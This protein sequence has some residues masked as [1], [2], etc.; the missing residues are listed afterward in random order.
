MGE[1]NNTLD[2][3]YWDCPGPVREVLSWPYEKTSEALR[4]I[5]GD[6][7]KVAG[8]APTYDAI[9]RQVER[10]ARQVESTR[11]GIGMWEGEAR[12][13]FDG[14]MVELQENLVSLAPAISQTQEILHSAAE[15]SVSCADL[16]LDIIRGV[17]E[18]LLSSL[19]VAGALV[20][21]T[22]GASA[23][24]WVAAN[25][26]KGAHALSKVL[27]GVE[28][29]VKVLQALTRTLTK[30]ETIMRKVAKVLKTIREV[31]Q[32]IEKAKKGAGLVDKAILTALA[33]PIK[34]STNAVS[35]VALDGVSAVTGVPGLSMPGG[36]GE[37]INAGE[38]MADAVGSSNDAVGAARD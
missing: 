6:P 20:V 33:A 25:L 4:F 2:T 9:A 30:I 21:V 16:I 23:A 10:M 5:T 18:F 1:Y 37:I 32:A 27:K 8:H 3:W 34:I 36:V 15:T 28:A 19:A 7:N 14:K 31:F 29:A 35:N 13:A 17:I 24:A 38:D 12:V 26:A 22:V 11:A